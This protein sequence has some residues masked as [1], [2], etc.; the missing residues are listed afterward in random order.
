MIDRPRE[1]L[2]AALRQNLRDEVSWTIYADWLSSQGDSRGELIGYEQRAEREPNPERA[3]QW[4]QQ[5]KLLFERDHP[6]WLGSLRKANMQPTW[7]RGFVS[8]AVVHDRPGWTA[9]TLLSM[10]TGALL[11]RLGFTRMPDCRP[12]AEAL[13]GSW[14]E[15][16]ELRSLDTA[17][18]EPL[19]NVESLRE[20]FLDRCTIDDLAALAELPELERLIIQNSELDLRAFERG[21]AK[22][23]H[24]ALVRHG[25]RPRPATGF[26]DLAGL[27]HLPALEILDLRDS[28]VDELGP[29][30]RLRK[31]RQLDI[32]GTHVRTLAPIEP[33][34]TL[35]RV[36]AISL[37]GGLHPAEVERLRARGV[38]VERQ[39]TDWR[40]RPGY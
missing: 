19:A 3:R 10:R 27:A 9:S 13:T 38:V 11:Y 17:T 1:L 18:I 2:E 40:L 7:T 8:E 6:R 4:R 16:L 14:I 21:F 23:R 29:L 39:S 34:E 30:A 36:D 37:N 35:E 22:L 20:L 15:V 25:W 32:S 24:L 12:V 26:V 33:I 31:L 5:A 28:R